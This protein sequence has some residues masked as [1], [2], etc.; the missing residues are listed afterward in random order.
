MVDAW[1][2]TSSLAPAAMI[3]ALR[4][5]DSLFTAGRKITRYYRLHAIWSTVLLVT[6]YF[7]GLGLGCPG[8]LKH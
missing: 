6:F 7:F 5:S 1:S 3:G 8:L 4:S 2:E